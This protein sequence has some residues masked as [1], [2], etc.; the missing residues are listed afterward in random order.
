MSLPCKANGIVFSC[1]G[2]GFCQP[3]TATA[4]KQQQPHNNM[5]LKSINFFQKTVLYHYHKKKYSLNLP[6]GNAH[7]HSD[8]IK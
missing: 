5:E 2:N 4:Y 1:I 3:S 6:D 7:L 8:I